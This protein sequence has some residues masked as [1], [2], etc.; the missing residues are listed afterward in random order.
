MNPFL[1]AKLALVKDT[2]GIPI[3]IELTTTIT[4]EQFEEIQDLNLLEKMNDF[5]R[6]E[7]E[8]TTTQMQTLSEKEI[9]ARLVQARLARKT[10]NFDK[11]EEI[12]IAES[13]IVGERS[14]EN[15]IIYPREA[16]VRDDLRKIFL[17]A[18]NVSIGPTADPVAG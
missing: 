12:H 6:A 4:M 7:M 8:K 1:N 10:L 11:T 13:I 18:L 17:D 9:W 5:L 16:S 3:G 14:N 2:F 15:W